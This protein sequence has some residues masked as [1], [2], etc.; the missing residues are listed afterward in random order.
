MDWRVQILGAL[1]TLFVAVLTAVTPLLVRSAVRYVEAKMKIDLS[2][3]QEAMLTRAAT[4][5]VAWVEEQSRKQLAKNGVPWPAEQKI[6]AARSFVEDVMRRHPHLD[7]S[8]LDDATIRAAIEAA[9]NWRRGLE[10]PK[11]TVSPSISL[12]PPNA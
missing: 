9:L 10:A 12:T 5:A 8:M 1:A 7:R 2:D 6:I 3:A 11:T 4:D